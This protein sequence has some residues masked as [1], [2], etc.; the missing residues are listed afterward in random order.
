MPGCASMGH[1]RALHFCRI[2]N[3]AVK[4]EDEKK[5][6]KLKQEHKAEV[7]RLEERVR[8][9]EQELNGLR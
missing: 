3:A 2:T 8:S 9:L 6:A 4:N 5:V 1:T 7:L